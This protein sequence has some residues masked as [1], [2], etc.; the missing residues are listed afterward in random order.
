MRPTRVC[1]LLALAVV[2]C[3]ILLAWTPRAHGQMVVNGAPAQIDVMNP[4]GTYSSTFWGAS[5]DLTGVGHVPASVSVLDGQWGTLIAPDVMVTAAHYF[6]YPGTPINFT[7]AQGQVFTYTTGAGVKAIGGSD[8]SIVMLTANVDPSLKVYGLAPAGDGVG[9]TVMA[10]GSQTGGAG[11][12]PVAAL[13]SIATLSNLNS[14]GSGVYASFNYSATAPLSGYYVAH[15]SGAPLFDLEP[16]GQLSLYGTA[17]SVNTGVASEVS[18]AGS[19]FGLLGEINAAI[20]SIGGTEFA[21]AY[22]VPP[23]PEPASIALLGVG[24][25][26]VYGLGF[27]R[28]RAAR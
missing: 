16:D 1:L 25:A 10:V 2:G 12:P 18:Y 9:T 3:L 8:L 24:L 11:S 5:S 17:L 26:V 20:A 15:D 21:T 6:L 23:S 14:S 19:G 4:N 27:R 28:R 13:G 22:I 7:N